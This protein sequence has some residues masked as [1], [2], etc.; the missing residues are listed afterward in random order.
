MVILSK[1]G[2][3]GSYIGGSPAR[4]D[5]DLNEILSVLGREDLKFL[6][7][8]RRKRRN[9]GIL[10]ILIGVGIFIGSTYYYYLFPTSDQTFL[11][12]FFGW[13]IAMSIVREGVN[14]I[15]ESGKATSPGGGRYKVMSQVECLKCGYREVLPYSPGD[16]VGKLVDKKCPKCS[17]DMKII[18]IFSEPEKKIRT[19]GMPILPGIGGTTG[20]LDKISLLLMRIFAPF[21]FAFKRYRSK[22][23]SESK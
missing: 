13:I 16:Y 23:N 10:A 18:K 21:G 2:D 12:V 1:A 5:R 20:V 15:T 9:M 6:R 22:S 11:W 19:V 3:E 8:L 4:S 7:E 17:G 14:I